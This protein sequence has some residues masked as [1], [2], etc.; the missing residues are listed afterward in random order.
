MAKV[1]ISVGHGGTDSGATGNGF[2][3]KD[4]NLSIALAVCNELVRHGVNVQMSRTKDEND[5]LSEEIAECNAYNPDYAV[6]IHNN[7]SENKNADGFEIYHHYN[8][9]KGRE[10][11]VNIEKEVIKLGQNSRG[12]KTRLGDDGRDYYGFIRRTVCPAVIVECAFITSKEDIK[13][14]DTETECVAMGKATAKGILKTLNIKYK[15]EKVMRFKDVPETHWAYKAIEE[16]AE[17]GI[18]KG[19]EDG[20]FKPL[21]NVTRAEIAVMLARSSKHYDASVSYSNP[22]D[23][24]LAES[25]YRN[26]VAFCASRGYLVGYP[27]GTFKPDKNLTRAEAAV[28][29]VR[30]MEGEK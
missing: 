23:D 11:A 8:G 14:I 5:T 18:T 28:I 15:E 17:K 19:Y 13:I 26:E 10:L 9:G 6:D 20:S 21:G 22:F 7:A 2:K 25:Y 12:V 30:F 3:E 16:L 1:F 4:L 29:M 24:V 27:D